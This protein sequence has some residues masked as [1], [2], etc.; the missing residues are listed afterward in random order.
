MLAIYMCANHYITQ[1]MYITGVFTGS[2]WLKQNYCTRA[3]EHS[4]TPLRWIQHLFFGQRNGWQKKDESDNL[5]IP[6]GKNENRFSKHICGRYIKY[7]SGMYIKYFS[8]RYVKFLKFYKQSI[9]WGCNMVSQ[10][11]F[12]VYKPALLHQHTLFSTHV[13]VSQ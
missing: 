6:S 7:F 1:H 11:L 12:F 3:N 9:S 5:T 4:D 8:G 13:A 10:S 2:D